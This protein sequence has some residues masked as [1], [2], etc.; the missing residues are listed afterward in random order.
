VNKEIEIKVC[1]GTGGIAAGGKEVLSAFKKTLP[2]AGIEASFL[3]NCSIHKVGCRGFCSKDVLVDIV[4]DG[5]KTTYENIKPD[6]VARIINEHIIGGNPIAEW[7]VGEAYNN[8]HKKQIKVVLSHCGE[9][10]PEDINAYIAA[11]GYEAAKK[12]LTSMSPENLVEVVS[13]SKL[14][15]RGGAGFPTGLKWELSLKIKSEVKYIICNGDEGDPGAF[16]DRSVMEG[17]PHSVIEGMIIC[18]KA[19][20]S[21]HGFMYVRAEYPL[22]VKRLQMAIDQCYEAGLLG[23]NI[24]GTGCDFDLKIFQGAGAFVCGEATALM[25]SI[26]GKRGMP[27][28]K[29]WRSAVKGLWGKPTVLNNVET[30]ANVPQIILKGADWFRNLGTE[31]S[32]GTKVFALTGKVKNAGLIEVPLG[33][34]LREIIYDI[35]GGIEG[36]RAL[37]A[38]Q[39]GGPSG[40][41]I[42][43]EL[44]DIEVD[45]E[46]LAQV[47]SIMGSGGMV[48]L[49]ETNCMVN[50]AKFFLEFTQAESCGKCIP[51]RIGTKRLLE[52]L[53]RI[54]S[55][56][57]KEG[58]I[59]LLEELSQDVKATSLCGL[60]MTAPNPILSTIKYFRHEYEAHIRDKKC[61]AAVCKDLITFSVLEEICTGCGACKRV[62]PADAIR[63]IRKMAHRIDPDLCVK[64]GT[65]FDVCKFKAILK[66]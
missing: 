49:D 37:K 64:C 15:G 6:M 12:A 29:L 5:E 44:L 54:T 57:G 63:G 59:E 30:F 52:I 40:G 19:T 10:D 47:G 18:A 7:T 13:A 41:C 46:S 9:I 45:Y 31:R 32:G 28:P 48:V 1:T 60:G 23:K 35:G 8:F 27:T 43:E 2:S 20:M 16:M 26:E 33:I 24:L 39:T 3:E 17:D 11:G 25:R 65:C 34:S 21:Q 38:V 51:C 36:D 66:K 4:I 14:R 22:A 50:T 56:K 58:D 42:P 53:A 55:G 61:P 62:C